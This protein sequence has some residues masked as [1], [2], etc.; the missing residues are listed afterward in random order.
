[1]RPLDATDLTAAIRAASLNVPDL[2]SLI[3]VIAACVA[4]LPD[5][6]AGAKDEAL[7]ALD[8]AHDKLEGWCAPD[9]EVAGAQR[10]QWGR[11][12]QRKEH[13]L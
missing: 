3:A 6:D 11:E 13:A 1:M 7:E 8:L 12:L 5:D 4:G 2:Q 10:A 9:A